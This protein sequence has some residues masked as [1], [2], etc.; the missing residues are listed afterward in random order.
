[1]PN[2]HRTAGN[3]QWRL[4]MRRAGFKKGWTKLISPAS[5]G[6]KRRCWG[7]TTSSKFKTRKFW[8]RVMHPLA[9][10]RSGPP[11]G[12]V[13]ALRYTA[14]RAGLPCVLSC[15]TRHR[16]DAHSLLACNCSDA[17]ACGAGSADRSDLG[18]VIRDG[19]GSTKSRPFGPCPRQAGHDTFVDHRAFELGETRP[20]SET[21][22]CRT[23]WSCRSL[24]DADT[25][26][27]P[28]RAVPAGCR[29]RSIRDRPSRSTLQAATIS[30]SFRATAWSSLLRPGRL[31]RPLAPLMPWSLKTATTCQPWRSATACSS[32]SWFLTVWWSVL[33]LT[34]RATRLFRFAFMVILFRFQ[35]DGSCTIIV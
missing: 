16:P 9:P 30:N 10:V 35:P 32:L 25:D 6:R 23:A 5:M 22:P 14:E 7:N 31:S 1:M 24:A 29:T 13:G 3:V 4:A 18:C 33:T 26:R 27:R 19:C 34:Y 20:S 12:R 11:R 15:K 8:R 2:P 28:W 17:L 21:S